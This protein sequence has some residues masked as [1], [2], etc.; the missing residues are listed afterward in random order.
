M[1]VYES[2]KT[3]QELMDQVQKDPDKIMK[4]AT[5]SDKAYTQQSSTNNSFYGG[6]LADLLND[7]NLNNYQ[8]E[9][10]AMQQN[11]LVSQLNTKFYNVKGFQ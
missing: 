3:R 1:V 8:Q 6:S 2:H 10:N 9:L 11:N 7:K 4:N 5:N